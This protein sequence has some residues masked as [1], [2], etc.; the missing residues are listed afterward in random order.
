VPYS[1]DPFRYETTRNPQ[2]DAQLLEE[3][4]DGLQREKRR[5][6]SDYFGMQLSRASGISARRHEEMDKST[7]RRTKI[8]SGKRVKQHQQ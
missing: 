6:E 8:S 3:K 5:L 4:L 7:S 2:V 1:P